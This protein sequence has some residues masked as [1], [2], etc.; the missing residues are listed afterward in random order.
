MTRACLLACIIVTLGRLAA[1]DATPQEQAL[2]TTLFNEAKTLLDAG[3]VPEACRKLEESQRIYPAGGTLL[4]L[5]VCHE[6]EGK[7]ASAW[8]EFRE[9]R[10][11]AERE[12]RDDRVALAEAHRNALE[13]KLSSS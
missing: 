3:R 7:T 5:A 12:G 9:A 2:A 10:V 6:K 1:A 8:A 13:P 4:N 11:I